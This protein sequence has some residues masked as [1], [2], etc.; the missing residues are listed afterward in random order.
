MLSPDLGHPKDCRDCDR[1][2][3]LT[4]QRLALENP[5]SV[6]VQTWCRRCGVPA[7][8]QVT[9]DYEFAKKNF[10]ALDDQPMAHKHLH[11]ERGG[12]GV[13]WRLDEVLVTLFPNEH[14]E[15]CWPKPP[16]YEHCE[17][18]DKEV[19]VVNP[20]DLASMERLVDIELRMLRE[21]MNRTPCSREELLAV[22]AEVYNREQV[23]ERYEVLGFRAPFAMVRERST[24]Q[25]GTMLFQHEP[26]FYFSYSRDRMI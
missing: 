11:A 10:Y 18:E 9:L 4:R 1:L 14:H 7:L 20:A 12:W 22:V 16:W 19:C 21:V 23:E 24:G 8:L 15:V 17:G 3:Q 13:H 25:M 26:R 5:R 6:A 2:R